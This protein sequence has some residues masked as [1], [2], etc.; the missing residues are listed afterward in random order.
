MTANIYKGIG[1]HANNVQLGD[2][3]VTKTEANDLEE[4]LALLFLIDASAD[5]AKTIRLNGK[6]VAG[7]C[8]W[9]LSRSEYEQWRG[10]NALQILWLFGAPGIGKTAIACFLIENLEEQAA[11]QPSIILIHHFCDYKDD[12]PRNSALGI[13]RCILY[14]LLK[15]QPHLFQW[16]KTKY[17]HRHERLP[18]VSNLDGLWAVFLQL[19]QNCDGKD[20]Y[21]L[22]D[23]LDECDEASRIALS[24]LIAEIPVSVSVKVL[25]TARS[26]VDIEGTAEIVG[27]HLRVDS[28]Q[29]NTDLAAFIDSRLVELKERRK[30]FPESLIHEIGNKVKNHAGGTFLWASLVFKDMFATRTSKAAARKLKHLP[31]DLPGIYKR[32]LDAIDE[33]DIED[34]AFI[35]RWTVVSKRPMNVTEMAT[36]QVLAHEGWS[37]DTVPPAEY[38]EQ[39]KDG[40]KACGHLIYYDPVNDTLN[41]IHRTAKDF[42]VEADC[43]PQYRVNAEAAG[44]DLIGTCWQYLTMWDVD[45]GTSFLLR[46]PQNTLIPRRLRCI[47]QRRYGFFNFA[48]DEV[49]DLEGEHRLSLCA[50]FVQ[51][52]R[53]INSLPLLRDFWLFHF[54]RAGHV[55]GVLALISKHA[56]VNVRCRALDDGLDATRLLLPQNLKARYHYFHAFGRLPPTLTVLQGAAERGYVEVCR[57][58]IERGAEVDAV[59]EADGE[60]ALHLAAE[61]GHQSVVCL[62]L[63]KGALVD[64]LDIRGRNPLSKALYAGW[65]QIGVLLL[66]RGANGFLEIPSRRNAKISI[67]KASHSYFSS[68]FWPRCTR[69]LETM[70][71]GAAAGGCIE[72]ANHL[73]ETGVT[74]KLR[75]YD[76]ETALSVAV[77][78][79]HTAV[80]KLLAANGGNMRWRRKNTGETLLHLATARGHL[81]TVAWL[82]QVVP[83]LNARANCLRHRRI[84]GDPDL[85]VPTKILRD[86]YSIQNRVLSEMI[87]PLQLAAILG[88]TEIY[89]VLI[90]AGADQST[91]GYNGR[92]ALDFAARYGRHENFVSINRLRGGN[93][94][95]RDEGGWTALHY[96]ATQGHSEMVLQLVRGGRADINALTHRGET[97]LHL[98]AQ[99]LPPDD[100]SERDSRL[101]LWLLSRNI[102]SAGAMLVLLLEEGADVRAISSVDGNTALH[103]AAMQGNWPA[104]EILL[105]YGANV[106]SINQHG[107]KPEDLTTADWVEAHRLGQWNRKAYKMTA[108]LLSGDPREKSSESTASSSTPTEAGVKCD[109]SRSFAPQ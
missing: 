24:G 88:H 26:E 13:I 91:S 99:L 47:D 55:E 4:F 63:D 70:L 105:A 51:S 46:N 85:E 82:A 23:A 94:N 30:T 87:T 52:Y 14:Q 18:L 83:D 37:M 62:L 100:G 25:I 56:D 27:R 109:S 12:G 5:L 59:G 90:Q 34:A 1:I 49:Q 97:A 3:Y 74:V 43:P 64:K 61:S 57:A 8:E 108:Q 42:L 20:V 78:S 106:H 53:T 76:S 2:T 67:M 9:I 95:D 45:Q 39:Y 16:I 60:S 21:I 22:I 11:S 15:K 86:F 103:F 84:P 50:A 19:L 68:D 66:A 65:D 107:E 41:L 10:E 28:G 98:V 73:L 102:S 33:D 54:A 36:A 35:L 89:R 79:G 32:N 31:S 48:F 17:Q 58:L 69:Q 72:S 77:G 81:D 44:I 96:A 38:L 104:T 7:T 40:F 93:I 71:F 101:N 29:I 92:N 6:R 80:A 75:R